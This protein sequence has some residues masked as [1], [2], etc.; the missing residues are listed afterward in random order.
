MYKNLIK[1][2][3]TLLFYAVLGT[4]L[5]LLNVYLYLVFLCIIAFICVVSGIGLN[6]WSKTYGKYVKRAWGIN[7]LVSNKA[8]LIGVIC[9]LGG[10]A[11]GMPIS[12]II[13]TYIL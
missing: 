6:T 9:N 8:Y 12:Y 4:V 13:S 1:N 5:N 3:L 10:F 7:I 11:L 2:T